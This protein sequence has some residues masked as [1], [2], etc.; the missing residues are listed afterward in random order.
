[1]SAFSSPIVRPATERDAV[2]LGRLAELDSAPPLVGDVLLAEESGVVVAATSIADG[3][4]IADPFRLTGP[5]RAALHARAPVRSGRSHPPRIAPRRGSMRCCGPPAWSPSDARPPRVLGPAYRG[6]AAMAAPAIADAL[7]DRLARYPRMRFM[8]SK[9]RLARRLADVFAALPPG[10]AV[11][12]FSG[13]GVVAYTLKATGRQV[14]ANDHLAFAAAFTQAMVA[15]DDVL[16]TPADVDLL[17]SPNR[18][19]R[20]FIQR[21]FDGLYFPA[22]DHAFLD[23]AWSH[24]DDMDATRRALA[25]SALCLAAA[26]KQPR[27]VFTITTLRYDDGRRQ[28]RMSL[29]DLFREAVDDVNAAVFTGPAEPSASVCGEV[30]DLDPAGVAVAYL[31]PPYAPPRDDT[32]YIKRYHFLEG[33]ATYWRGQEIMWGTRSRKLVKRHTPFASRRTVSRCARP[34]V[35]A[36]P[37][38]HRGRVLRVQRRARRRGARGAHAPSHDS[39][40]ADRDPAHLRVRHARHRAP[41]GGDGVRPGRFGAE[42]RGVSGLRHTAEGHWLEQAAP[43]M[44]DPAPPPEGD[45]RADVVVVGGGYTGM[46]CA[47][48]LAELAPDARIVV[49]EADLCGHGPSGRNGGFCHGNWLSL[50]PLRDRLGAGPALELA[51]ATQA[52][53]EAIGRWCEEQDV[54]AWYRRGGELRVSTTEAHDD[55]GLASARAA[56]EL[57]VGDRLVDLTPAH[58]RAHC[59]SPVFRRGVFAPDGATVHPGRLALGLRARLIGRGVVVH[60]HA[61]VLRVRG[62]ERGRCQRRDHGGAHPR[63]ARGACRRRG[64]HADARD[65]RPGPRRNPAT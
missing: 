13:S 65:A 40:E 15:N 45:V 62:E 28:L 57:G 18:D 8:G 3:R 63:G 38:S 2:A 48:H 14:L 55:V 25:I 59:D 17:C 1:M 60:E 31:D 20:D 44:T 39:G 58:V 33:L 12:A 7:Q 61:R 19:G 26:R 22:A 34:H 4:M 53:A 5:A 54:D 32:C 56:D 47:W 29:R 42:G 27:G 52:G 51:R 36:F 41:S 11:D 49:L 24:L 46:W 9:H 23:A 37:R 10:P 16:L 6:A 35:R 43:L 30:F 50:A 64:A 21:T